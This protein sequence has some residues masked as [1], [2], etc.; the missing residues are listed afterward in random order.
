[1]RATLLMSASALGLLLAAAPACDQKAADDCQPGTESCSCTVD[2]RCLEGL[3]CLSEYCVDPDWSPEVPDDDEDASEDDDEDSNED[4]DAADSGDDNGDDDGGD[5][6]G[7]GDG[8]AVDNVGACENW[9]EAAE[10]GDYDWSQSVDC[11]IY[12]NL[13]CDIADYF[14]C[15]SENTACNDGIPD[16]SGWTACAELATC[17]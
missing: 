6:D 5:D 17:A 4:D 8:G 1:M 11:G 13:A 16:T 12:A 15:L 2:Y 7:G 14:N 3:T 10:C 9:I